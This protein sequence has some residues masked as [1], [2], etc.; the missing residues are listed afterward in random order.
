VSELAVAV[1]SGDKD[2]AFN[3]ASKFVAPKRSFLSSALLSVRDVA[4][5]LG[6]CTQSVWRLVA[7]GGFPTPIYIGQSLRWSIADVDQYLA[8]KLR[9]RGKSIC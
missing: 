8:T 6:I 2:S 9:N 4:A 5:R 3:A 7:A 1:A